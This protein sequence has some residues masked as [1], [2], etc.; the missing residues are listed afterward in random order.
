MK[1]IMLDTSFCIRLLKKDD[2]FHL[3][4]VD[5]FEY[6]LQNKVELYISTIVV[7]E[8]SV[9]DDPKNLPLKTM[10]IVPFDFN[11]AK[12]AG[13]FHQIL[14]A[15]K[16]A[17]AQEDRQA[18]KDDCKILAQI[19]NRNIEAYITK[20]KNSF[21]TI[22]NPIIKQANLKLE[23]LDLSIPLNNYKNEFP[24]PKS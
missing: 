15:N 13:E 9:K 11:D 12:L 8:Y 6:F 18:I 3:N 21:G 4:T 24:F 17:W 19:T 23:L 10:R 16:S 20:D 22:I 7:A 14:L 2:E 1:S 5:Y